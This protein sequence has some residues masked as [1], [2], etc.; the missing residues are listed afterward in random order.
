M[1][2][3]LPRAV[4]ALTLTKAFYSPGEVAEIASISS[5]TVLNYIKAG[6]VPAVRLSERT[7]RIPRK[8]LIRFLGIEAPEP[9]VIEKPNAFVDR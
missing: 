9:T 7:L 8:A 6:R 1:T 5:S 4:D 2:L 3:T